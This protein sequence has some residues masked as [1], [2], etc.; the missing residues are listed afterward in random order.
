VSHPMI[1]GI[2]AASRAMVTSR[3]TCKVTTGVLSK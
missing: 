1:F 2:I 3:S